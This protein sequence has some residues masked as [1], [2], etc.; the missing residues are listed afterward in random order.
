MF[1]NYFEKSPAAARVIPFAVFIF[2]T[3]AQNECGETARYWIYFLKSLI[4]AWLILETWPFVK[5]MRLSF[6]WE[7]VAVGVGVCVMW[8]GLDEFYPK[9]SELGV[10]LGLSKP[11]EHPVTLLPWNPHAQFGHGTEWAWSFIAVRI[12]GSSLVVPFLEEVFFRSFLYRYI[13]SPDFESV[14][15][16]K[17]LPLP[18]FIVACVFAFEHEQWLAGILCAFAYQWLVLRKKRLGD[19]IVAHGITNFLLGVWVVCK[20]AWQ[21]W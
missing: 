10:K 20:G 18:F 4:G 16:G 9:L 5:E 13:A 12:L 7:A 15:L 1:R 3:F 21:F 11:P 14:P 17:F 2:F 19:A 6:S 8:V